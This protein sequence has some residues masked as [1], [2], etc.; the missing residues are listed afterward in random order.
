RACCR[1]RHSSQMKMRQRVIST[2]QNN[3]LGTSAEPTEPRERT[4]W[5]LAFLCL[6]IPFLPSLLVPVGPL[7]SNGSPAK[8]IAILFFGF[9]ILGF[10]LIRRTATTRSLRPGVVLILV[11]FLLELVTYGVGRTHLGSTLLEANKTRWI[12]I[13][14]A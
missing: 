9:A 2:T 14:L 12:I 11:Y 1:G 4:P 6:L 8:V 7:K 10:F 13:L 5:L 3:R